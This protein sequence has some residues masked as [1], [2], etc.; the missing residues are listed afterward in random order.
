M[1]FEKYDY[2]LVDKNKNKNQ[3]IYQNNFA[4]L[5]IAKDKVSINDYRNNSMYVITSD[6]VIAMADKIKELGGVRC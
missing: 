5:I 2:K 1:E 6:L 4:E 3:Y